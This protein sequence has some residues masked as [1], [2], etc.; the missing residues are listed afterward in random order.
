VHEPAVEV[1]RTAADSVSVDAQLLAEADGGEAV[2]RGREG[3]A[4]EAGLVQGR[5][6]ILLITSEGLERRSACQ[7]GE[8][9]TEGVL[10]GEEVETG[11]H[12]SDA[13]EDANLPRL[14][15]ERA[16]EIA[17]GVDTL[18]EAVAEGGAVCAASGPVAAT[19]ENGATGET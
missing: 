1:E 3:G 9:P 16:N 5:A 8:C 2:C 7:L 13:I 15:F 18:V 11:E 6:D 17:D 14:K 10:R 19:W 12:V 4:Q